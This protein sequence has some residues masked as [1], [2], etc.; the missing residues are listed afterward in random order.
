[1]LANP[2]QIW[3][4]NQD[5]KGITTRPKLWSRLY[6][7]VAGIAIPASFSAH[8][9]D[10]TANPTDTSMEQHMTPDEQMGFD[11]GINLQVFEP[12]VYFSFMEAHVMEHSLY[13]VEGRGLYWL[14]HD[15]IEV[16]KDDFYL[17]IPLL[18]TIFLCHWVGKVSVSV[19]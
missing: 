5:N 2:L 13:M 9:S 8:E 17:Y 1:L 4:N 14:N 7:E 18:P 11:M 19:V 16:Q 3:V 15:L 6:E 12:G 10:V